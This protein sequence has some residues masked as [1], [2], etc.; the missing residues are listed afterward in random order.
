[1]LTQEQ[2]ELVSLVQ[3]LDE[4]KVRK[5]LE[6]ARALA[7]KPDPTVDFADEWTEEDYKALSDDTFR[8]LQET[9]PYDW[10][11]SPGGKEV[12]S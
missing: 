6:Y 3:N 10:P 2:Q 9:D 4:T 5:I 12:A 11:E 7:L 1:M 8:R